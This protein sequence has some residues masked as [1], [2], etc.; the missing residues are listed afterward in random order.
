MFG[1]KTGSYDLASMFS[2]STETGA[3]A[4]QNP[5]SP[6]PLPDIAHEILGGLVTAQAIMESQLSPLE[7]V[8][9][10]VLPVGL[11]ILGGAPKAGKSYLALDIAS[12]VAS[13]TPFLGRYAANAGKVLYIT[14][15]D[16]E[17]RLRAR[18]L[19]KTSG[20]EGD[21]SNL[22]F[23]YRWPDFEHRGLEHLENLVP[24]IE[25]V[26]L[27][28]I[29]TLGCF[30]GAGVKQSYAFQY[31]VM[32]QMSQV[33]NRLGV[34]LLVIHHTVK[35]ARSKNWKQALYGTNAVSGGADGLLM[36]DRTGDGEG[37]CANLMISGRDV[38][39]DSLSLRLD[40]GVWRIED[41][42]IAGVDLLGKPGQA[43]VYRVL[44]ASSEPLAFREIVAATGKS[45]SNVGNMLKTMVDQG[46]VVK[47]PGKRTDK[48][49]VTQGATTTEQ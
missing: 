5:F 1:S 13:G 2:S 26:K 34:S 20:G 30:L 33:A 18:L 15:E 14:Y 32:A 31:Q 6:K 12:A 28:V 47:A 39:D 38:E 17:R 35:T 43:E 49:T 4:P 9:D 37:Q 22:H 44:M 23:H 29:D 27:V 42:Q 8:I 45:A 40:K 25:G 11:S 3:V 48:Y 41:S 21:L 36:L 10:G 7:F 19:Q 24:Q 16:T 46:L